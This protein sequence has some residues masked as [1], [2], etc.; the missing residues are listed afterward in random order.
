MSRGEPSVPPFEVL[1]VAAFTRKSRYTA[2][3]HSHADDYEIDYYCGGEASVGIGPRWYRLG[4]DDLYIAQPGEMHTVREKGDRACAVWHLLFRARSAPSLPFSL[5][6]LPSVVRAVRDPYLRDTWRRLIDEYYV[7][8]S[9]WE[10]LCSNLLTELILCIDRARSRGADTRRMRLYTASDLARLARARSYIHLFYHEPITLAALAQV[11]SM[12]RCRFARAFRAYYGRTPMDYVIETRIHH[13][14]ELLR[15]RRYSM[16]EVA[17][18][19]GYRSAQYFSRQFRQR[20]GVPPSAYASGN[21]AE[22]H[23]HA[24]LTTSGSAG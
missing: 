18:M 12:S 14:A 19:T 13:A 24:G 16:S 7:R 6:S 11:A 9:R 21:P 1:R 5:D 23:A 17:A 4:A 22:E 10:W 15:E 20:R 3:P 8:Q 2:L